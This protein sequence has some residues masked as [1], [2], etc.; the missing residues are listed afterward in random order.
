MVR[1][2]ATRLRGFSS[3]GYRYPDPCAFR[4][5]LGSLPVLRPTRGV[6]QHSTAQRDP[7]WTGCNWG[8]YERGGSRPASQHGIGTALPHALQ[9][10]KTGN[11][12]RLLFFD[13]MWSPSAR[14]YRC[15]TPLPSEDPI[16][17]RISVPITYILEH[18]QIAARHVYQSPLIIVLGS[19]QIVNYNKTGR[20]EWSR[21]RAWRERKGTGAGMGRQK[22]EITT[23][24]SASKYPLKPTTNCSLRSS[25]KYEI[26]LSGNP[27]SGASAWGMKKTKT[28]AEGAGEES[29]VVMETTAT[30]RGGGSACRGYAGQGDGDKRRIDEHGSTGDGVNSER[31]ER[32]KAPSG[33]EGRQ[34]YAEGLEATGRRRQRR[35]GRD[36]EGKRKSVQ[37]KRGVIMKVEGG[38]MAG[39][40]GDAGKE[41]EGVGL[42]GHEEEEEGA[43]GR[44]DGE[45][46]GRVGMWE[47]VRG[48]SGERGYHACST[49]GKGSDGTGEG[50]G[51]AKKGCAYRADSGMGEKM[52]TISLT[53]EGEE[54][55]GRETWEA[56]GQGGGTGGGGGCT[57]TGEEAGGGGG[58]A[59]GGDGGEKAI[60]RGDG[61]AG[62]E[63]EAEQGRPQRESPLT[64]QREEGFGRADREGQGRVRRAREERGEAGDSGE[65]STC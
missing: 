61:S 2:S 26:V 3:G 10:A 58:G 9:A 44:E 37:R 14:S 42:R 59:E 21:A 54:S 12:F 48:R 65:D 7:W 63:T 32:R 19:M 41:R 4:D 5:H 18:H 46:S 29:R 50:D 56:Q 28:Q 15:G 38:E 57:S 24:V 6:G 39:K 36:S 43:R 17:A 60:R 22:K 1:P 11:P 16:A 23:H 55:V 51:E 13:P 40:R 8:E 35:V 31:T 53:C 52:V 64:C 30:A 33:W 49:K 62:R 25:S 27:T 20:G 45:G 34:G 47:I